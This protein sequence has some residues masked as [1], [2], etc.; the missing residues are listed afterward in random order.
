MF[1]SL[2][3]D[4]SL[5][6]ILL[7]QLEISLTQFSVCFWALRN[8]SVFYMFISL[9]PNDSLKRILLLQLQTCRQYTVATK[10][11]FCMISE[12]CNRQKNA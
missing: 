5:K 10:D 3:P 8:W 12:I 2:L 1:I 9:L 7:L 4:D 6:R 11:N